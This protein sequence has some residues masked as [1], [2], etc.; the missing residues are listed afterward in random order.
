MLTVTSAS[1]WDAKLKGA[2]RRSHGYIYLQIGY[3]EWP[4][5]TTY[6]DLFY[7][8]LIVAA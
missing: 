2:E 6:H 5:H 4:L 7:I 3:H 1:L 8:I